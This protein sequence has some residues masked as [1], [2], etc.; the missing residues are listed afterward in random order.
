[1]YRKSFFNPFA[2]LLLTLAVLAFIVDVVLP[3]GGDI[4]AFTPIV[5]F[6][7]WLIG[8]FVRLFYEKEAKCSFEGHM[9]EA[10]HAVAWKRNG[11]RWEQVDVNN[12][13][14]GDAI[15]VSAGMLCPVD[16]SLISGSVLASESSLT[17]ESGLVEKKEGSILRA[18]VV[19]TNGQAVAEVVSGIDEKNRRFRFDGGLCAGYAAGAKDVCLSFARC[20][21]V[22]VPFVLFVRGVVLGD[23]PHALLF[24]LGAA[25]GLV[26]EMLPVVN[27][28]CLSRGARRLKGKHVIVKSVDAMESLGS[29]DVVCVDKTGTLTEDLAMLEYYVDVLGNESIRT[30]GLAYLECVK[31]GATLNQLNKAVV[32][33]CD[34]PDFHFPTR[35]LAGACDSFETIPFDHVSKS[36]GVKLVVAPDMLKG[37]ALHGSFGD[38]LTIVKGEV[39]SVCAKCSQVDI[40]GEI[41]PMGPDGE[42]SILDAA[43]EMRSDGI[44]V[45]AVAYGFDAADWDGLVLCGFL[46]FF[47]APK[48]SARAAVSALSDLSVEVRVLTGDSLSVARSVCSRLGI[49][50][51]DVVTGAMLAEMT[52]SEALSRVARTYVFAEL[53]P[54]QKAQIVNLLGF[55][56]HTVGYIGDGVN[57]VPALRAADVGI[58]VDSAAVESKKAA[59]LVLLERD[60]GVVAEGVREGRKAFANASKY[61]R[62]AS[63]SNFGNICSV[64]AASVFLPFLPAT[65]SQL[66][67]LN[68]S[69]DAVCL[70]MPWDNVDDEEINKP[71]MWTGKGLGGFMACFGLASAVF[72]VVAFAILFFVVCPMACG[73]FYSTLDSAGRTLFIAVF[74]SGWLLECVWT[75]SLVILALRTR[76]FFGG[77]KACRSL[78]AMVAFM[79]IASALLLLSPASSLLGLAPMPVWY[80]G[81]VALLSVLYLTLVSFFK[82]AYLSR[83]ENLF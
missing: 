67:V 5:L 11:G 3:S 14:P 60:L 78:A 55:A 62:I 71:K 76:H 28:A 16:V 47:D 53:T 2:A 19:I 31:Q 24:A 7:M 26:P 65:A 74:Q 42:K 38:G 21:I 72:D 58:V 10:S 8:G 50:S 54:A 80:L 66:L 46:G 70:A 69:Y 39:E 9:H 44:K 61:V 36:S 27:G 20:M 43:E 37:L 35:D 56:G 33:A 82:R 22:I 40:K 41:V 15:R 32:S 81:V 18:G 48:K 64:A 83:A 45:L 51:D 52:E 30:L 23:W 77:G 29:M 49:P 75:Q 4:D 73:G 63:S 17:G 6:L 34:S 1:M 25:V 79:L 13:R 12:L 57:D 59:D 68:L